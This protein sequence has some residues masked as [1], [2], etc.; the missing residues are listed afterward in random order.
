MI[1]LKSCPFCG[2]TKILVETIAKI[3]MQD[4][5][6]PDYPINSQMYAAVCDYLSGGCGASTGGA[7]TKMEA[8]EAWNRRAE[9]RP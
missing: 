1:V 6:H 3:E 2:G 9:E 5:D 7:H 4:P 8:A